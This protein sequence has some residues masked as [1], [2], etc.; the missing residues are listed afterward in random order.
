MVASKDGCAYC[1]TAQQ[2][3]VDVYPSVCLISPLMTKGL[4]FTFDP[5]FPDLR[6]KLEQKQWTQKKNHNTQQK[7]CSFFTRGFW[8]HKKLWLW[9]QMGSSNYCKQRWF[10]VLHCSPGKWIAVEKACGPDQETGKYYR[11]C[12]ARRATLTTQ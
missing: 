8:V 1:S 4:K 2:P 7:L 5:L 10:A 3:S 9:T 12:A 11:S 6:A